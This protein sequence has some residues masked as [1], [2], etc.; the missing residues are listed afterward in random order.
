MAVRDSEM[1]V[2]CLVMLSLLFMRSYVMMLKKSREAL[3]DGMV[4]LV[5][6]SMSRGRPGTA[7]EM[8]LEGPSA[9]RI[10]ERRSG[11][12]A[13]CQAFSELGWCL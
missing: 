1:P 11:Y 8:V 2:W 10:S 13:I 6:A 5:N 4:V 12:A 9:E 3:I 7:A